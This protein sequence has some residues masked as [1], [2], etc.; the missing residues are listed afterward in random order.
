MA[1]RIFDSS[2]VDRYVLNELSEEE[3]VEFEAALFESQALRR[4][5]EAALSLQSILTLDDEFNA[6]A[7]S[8]TERTPRR[9]RPWQPLAIQPACWGRRARAVDHKLLGESGQ[10]SEL[11]QASSEI[12]IKRIDVT[13]SSSAARG[14]PVLRPGG[15][16]LLVMDIELSPRTRDLDQLQIEFVGDDGEVVSSWSGPTTDRG[17]VTIGVRSTQLEAGPMAIEF[18]NADGAL[19]DRRLLEFH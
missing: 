14:T 18:R 2:W 19:L 16:S 11:S 5:V 13:R 1:D 8:I 17:R 4:D 15:N 9:V 6:K 3:A 7:Q 10:V 12:V